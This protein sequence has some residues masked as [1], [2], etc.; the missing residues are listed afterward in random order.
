VESDAS[1]VARVLAVLAPRLDDQIAAELHGRA[2]ARDVDVDVRCA[3]QAIAARRR[4]AAVVRCNVGRLRL[5]VGQRLGLGH[6]LGIRIR[7]GLR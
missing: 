1:T 4:I 3:L 5:R 2:A 7:L 6:R